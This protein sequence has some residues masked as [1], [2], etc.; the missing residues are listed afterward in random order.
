MR[1][2]C[3]L[4]LAAL[5]A[6]RP[7]PIPAQ[8]EQPVATNT[9][10][11]D[12]Q[13]IALLQEALSSAGTTGA[14]GIQDFTETGNITY[15]WAGEEVSGSV[16]LR[17]LGVSNFRFDAVVS[18]DSGTR[19]WAVTDGQGTTKDSSGAATLIP[20]WNGTNLGQLTIPHLAIAAALNDTTVSVT[21]VGQATVNGQAATDIRVQ[22][23]FSQ[24]DDPSGELTKWSIRDYLLDPVTH[25]VVEMQDTIYANDSTSRTYFHELIFSNFQVQDG[26]AIPYSITE[27]VIGQQTWT[28]QI[29]STSFNIGLTADIFTL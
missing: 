5:T 20:L 16:T 2:I 26:V 11:R 17:G 7:V 15:Y 19:S 13:A 18:G 24:K 1:S 23:T 22:K 12:P 9:A 29:S 3:A 25:A 4:A 21:L 27:K 28:I 10:V 8:Q 14:A 6:V